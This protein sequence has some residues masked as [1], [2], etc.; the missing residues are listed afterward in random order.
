MRRHGDPGVRRVGWSGNPPRSADAGERV[1]SGRRGSSIVNPATG[2]TNPIPIPD[3]T[4][5]NYVRGAVETNA[6]STEGNIDF[7]IK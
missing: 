7:K 6:G 2:S 5:P 4:Q 3:G 1:A